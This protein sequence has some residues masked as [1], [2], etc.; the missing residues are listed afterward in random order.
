MILNS[1]SGL[2]G[3]GAVYRDATAANNPASAS[4]AFVK[5]PNFWRVEAF[6][7]YQLF[8]RVDLQRNLNNSSDALD[9]KQYCAGQAVPGARVRF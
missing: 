4:V 6:A 3:A 7:S 9:Y 5:V 1:H 8:N 2:L